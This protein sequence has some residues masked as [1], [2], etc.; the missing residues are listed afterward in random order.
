MCD[1]LN[2]DWILGSWTA[3]MPTGTF[4]ETWT[5]PSP[6]VYLG[7]GAR[8]KDGSCPFV[9]FM[10]IEPGEEGGS[11]LWMVLGK[12]SAG[13]PRVEPFPITEIEA[14]RFVADRGGDDSPAAIDYERT[15]TGMK[16][17]LRDPNGNPMQ[18]FKFQR[19]FDQS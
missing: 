3:E 12:P 5:S 16:C 4:E 11:T 15:S 1:L 7:H 10:V 8:V 18:V 6:G 14:D 9:E 17:T 19:S 13:P 2:F